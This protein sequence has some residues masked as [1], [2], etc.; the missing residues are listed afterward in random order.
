MKKFI[1]LLAAV[2]ILSTNAAASENNSKKV[3][4]TITIDTGGN[5]GHLVYKELYYKK[6]G[7]GNLTFDTGRIYFNRSI[8]SSKI[9]I[10]IL[11]PLDG[12]GK[13]YPESYI[14]AVATLDNKTILN[15]WYKA[16]NG[17]GVEAKGTPGFDV[18]AFL[19]AIWLV[20]WGRK[21]YGG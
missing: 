14:K 17:A 5:T 10:E 3:P 13:P 11:R 16:K 9:K 12:S 19:A 1:I 2:L 20:V 15:N 4:V 18:P 7:S 21:R 8:N 6:D